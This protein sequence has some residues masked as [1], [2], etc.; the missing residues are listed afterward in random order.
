LIRKK[1]D[2]VLNTTKEDFYFFFNLETENL[3]LIIKNEE[4][5]YKILN[6][7]NA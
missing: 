2:D 1:I 6:I 5:G 3:S 4:N 7:L